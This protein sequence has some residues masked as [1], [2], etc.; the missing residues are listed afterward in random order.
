MAQFEHRPDNN[1]AIIDDEEPATDRRG[2]N[3]LHSVGIGNLEELPSSIRGELRQHN[4]S[5]SFLTSAVIGLAV[6]WCQFRHQDNDICSSSILLMAAL[7]L[8]I[9]IRSR[10]QDRVISAA[11]REDVDALE[12][13]VATVAPDRQALDRYSRVLRTFV[14]DVP[15]AAEQI[16]VTDMSVRF[17]H[18]VRSALSQIGG[19]GKLA[20]APLINALIKEPG[21]SLSRCLQELQ[22]SAPEIRASLAKPSASMPEPL[23]FGLNFLRN[24]NNPSEESLG[25]NV[26]APALATMFR[27]ASDEFCLG[28]FG[29]W[30]IGKSHLARRVEQLLVNP[31]ASQIALGE[32]ACRSDKL[33]MRYE[34]VKFS[35]WKYRCVPEAWVALYEAFANACTDCPWWLKLLRKLRISIAR[36]GFWPLTGI[37][38]G[39]GLAL[40]PFGAFFSVAQAA[41][42]IIGIFGI[43]ALITVLRR[44][45]GHAKTLLDRYS[46][47]ASHREALGLQATIGE[48]LRWL[49]SGWVPRGH[50]VKWWQ[51]FIA[52]ALLAIICLLWWFHLPDINSTKLSELCVAWSSPAFA[53]ICSLLDSNSACVRWGIFSSYLLLSI[54]LVFAPYYIGDAPHRVLL[55]V[56]DLDR[57]SPEEL[58]SLVESIKLLLE[59]PEFQDRIQVLMLVDELALKHAIRRKFD[60][61]INERGGYGGDERMADA[62]VWEHIEKLFACH[63]R[64]PGLTSAEVEDLTMLYANSSNVSAGG[65][66]GISLDG[67]PTSRDHRE[68]SDASS[69]NFELDRP[70]ASSRAVDPSQAAD[71]GAP[72][73]EPSAVTTRQLDLAQV[74]FTS[75]QAQLIANRLRNACGNSSRQIT[76]RVIRHFLYKVQL[77][78]LLSL[79]CNEETN[80][81][82]LVD[83]LIQ[84]GLRG[85]PTGS[86]PVERTSLSAIVS[87]VA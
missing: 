45:S 31:S 24:V 5:L 56:D 58:L 63:L 66:A 16:S 28:I 4:L 61:V 29:H 52:I 1:T 30:G 83:I 64:L 85:L 25:I 37:I 3:F 68:S 19:E 87:Q 42:S 57:C 71:Y 39:A 7:H 75:N 26:Y 17:S 23:A 65:A 62:V 78:R 14:Q 76:P 50:V 53:T 77:C 60:S 72:S 21:E 69:A 15:S 12:A 38:G 13:L 9:R 35:A 20:L 43:L 44:G 79:L 74:L 48:S 10:R 59:E 8:G 41:A 86:E 80:L 11:W 27:T 84:A 34:V 36:Q 82:K 18:G 32:K 46:T 2:W 40:M 55:V 81:D 22:V 33:A 49:M 47:I 67:E 6:R 73:D 54:T 51:T 70:E